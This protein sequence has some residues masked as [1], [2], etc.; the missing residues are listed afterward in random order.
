MAPSRTKNTGVSGPG[1]CDVCQKDIKRDFSRHMLQHGEPLGI[2]RHA[3]PHEWIDERGR[4]SPC[5]ATF[6]DQGALTRHRKNMHG[7]VPKARDNRAD[8]VRFRGAAQQAEDAHRY[9]VVVVRRAADRVARKRAELNGA[10]NAPASASNQ[11][12]YRVAECDA[13]PSSS[14]VGPAPS[15][16]APPTPSH[17]SSGSAVYA[18][19]ATPIP[20][21]PPR[22]RTA[23]SAAHSTARRAGD[24]PDIPLHTRDVARTSYDD[25]P[26]IPSGLLHG[27]GR[28]TPTQPHTFIDLL[29]PHAPLIVDHCDVTHSSRVAFPPYGRDDVGPR[30]SDSEWGLCGSSFAM[31]DAEQDQLSSWPAQAATLVYDAPPVSAPSSR[32]DT[33][34]IDAWDAY[35]SP[36]APSLTAS[37]SDGSSPRPARRRI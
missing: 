25:V 36:T 4:I 37:F 5:V 7:Y 8:G 21:H 2:R 20:L 1:W 29:D 32:Q 17:K 31:V 16:H 24:S 30:T 10:E 15:M 19:V 11:G 34:G 33:Y 27:D 26:F 22:P 12:P 18:P 6:D 35:Y 9:G 13:G 23:A 28:W 3:C 14:I